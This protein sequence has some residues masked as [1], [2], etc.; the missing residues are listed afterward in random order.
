[1][2][3]EGGALSLQSSSKLHTDTETFP[4]AYWRVESTSAA[5]VL[6]KML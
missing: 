4:S 5:E 6:S 1:M 2:E 3:E